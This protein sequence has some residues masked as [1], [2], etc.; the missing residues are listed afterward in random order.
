[1]LAGH[2][3]NQ[4]GDQDG[5]AHARAAEQPRLPAS[6]ERGQQVDDLTSDAGRW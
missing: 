5:L 3:V 6:L 4:F 2:V 1:M